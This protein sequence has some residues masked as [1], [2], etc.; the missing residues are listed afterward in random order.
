MGMRLLAGVATRLGLHVTPSMRL[1][2]ELLELPAAELALRLRLEA[3]RNPWL[4]LDEEESVT[5]EPAAGSPVVGDPASPPEGP[6]ATEPSTEEES[7]PA[8]TVGLEWWR[9]LGRDDATSSSGAAD[10]DGLPGPEL[11]AAISLPEFLR[12]QLA[13]TAERELRGIAVYLIGCIDERGRLG[14]RTE[15]AAFELG[16]RPE[17]VERAIALLQELDPPGIAARDLRECLLLQLERR[18]RIASP[19]ARL[20]REAFELI[21]HGRWREAARRA[22]VPAGCLEEARAEIRRLHPHPGRLVAGPP[23]RYITP[24]VHVRRVGAGFVV[25]A[26]GEGPAGP[27]LSRW[28]R[29][30]QGTAGRD[31][32]VR[33]WLRRNLVS[34]RRLMRALDRR[35]RTLVRVTECIVREQREFFER[36]TA[37]LRPMNLQTVARQVGL[38]ESTVARAVRGK[39]AETPL[40]LVP[41]RHFFSAGLGPPGKRWSARAICERIRCL[42]AEEDPARPWSDAQ[43]AARLSEAGVPV[44]RRTVTKYRQTIG[45]ERAPRRRKVSPGRPG[46]RAASDGSSQPSLRRTR[47]RSSP[48]AAGT[49]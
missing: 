38:H 48:P 7:L 15:E 26:A 32:E 21:G 43:L 8:D 10:R 27:G 24:D 25:D 19:A 28:C 39:Y 41:L 18:G 46:R 49:S 40:G 6:F 37:G 31:V 13:L 5:G 45:I 30:L 29:D 47:W 42:V 36:G 44:A 23:V 20:V 1:A 16:C 4:A 11:A 34:A 14:I 2:L 35:R 3:E 9:W 17:L 12:R 22:R 33:L